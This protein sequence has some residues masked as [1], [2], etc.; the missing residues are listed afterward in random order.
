MSFLASDMSALRRQ[1][2]WSQADL[3]RRLGFGLEQIR[4]WESGEQGIPNVV[5]HELEYL[6]RVSEGIAETLCLQAVAQDVLAA[7]RRTQVHRDELNLPIVES[8]E[9][10]SR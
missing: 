2:G 1:L 9:K 3:G 6:K 10:S 7:G 4:A 5:G 8:P